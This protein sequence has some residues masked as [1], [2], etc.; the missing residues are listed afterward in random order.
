MAIFP[1]LGKSL[2]ATFLMR[3]SSRAIRALLI[4]GVAVLCWGG[5]SE[6]AWALQSHGGSEGVVVH[7]MAHSLYFAALLYLLW[8]VRRSGFSSSGWKFLKRFCWLMIVWNLLTFLGHFAQVA[9]PEEDISTDDGYL[10]A[11][12]LLPLTFD[13]WIY[14]IAGLDHLI[15]VPALFCLYLAMR[16]FYRSAMDARKE[17]Q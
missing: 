2:A 8:D 17:V 6:N 11:F 12:L 5:F 4:I 1:S 13:K 9:L 15:S 16:T 10:S 3:S 14:Y 7:Q